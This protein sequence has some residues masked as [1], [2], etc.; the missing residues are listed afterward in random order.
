[1]FWLAVLGGGA[2]LLILYA[3]VGA[4]GDLFAGLFNLVSIESSYGITFLN[5]LFELDVTHPLATASTLL[6]Y[7][8]FLTLIL[9]PLG[10]WLRW[11]RDGRVNPDLA[12]LWLTA[13][14]VYPILFL[15]PVFTRLT[16]TAQLC[17]VLGA[18]EAVWL[19]RALKRRWNGVERR[20]RA[21]AAAASLALAVIPL[22]FLVIVLLN[23]NIFFGSISVRINRP[24]KW[25]FPQAPIYEAAAP[26]TAIRD[27]AAQIRA[28]TRPDETIFAGYDHGFYFL[29]PRENPTGVYFVPDVLAVNAALRQRFLSELERR[30]PKLILR[31]VEELDD[32]T[33]NP[34]WWRDYLQA[35]YALASQNAAYALYTRAP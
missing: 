18:V 4:L 21:L 16:Q 25:D 22:S 15:R 9:C 12:A 20:G 35:H 28:R 34:P 23:N 8:S 6:V 5:P 27:M 30:P 32:P 7:A 14:A 2:P 1:L 13:C 29:L 11:R 10:L 26:T 3:G 24:V 19:V 31:R 33:A 17:Y